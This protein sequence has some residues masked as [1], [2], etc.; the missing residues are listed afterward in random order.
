MQHAT[1]S[2]QTHALPL[3]ASIDQ[4]NQL[5]TQTDHTIQQLNLA[6]S[7]LMQ[8]L[9]SVE[10]AIAETDQQARKLDA[11]VDDALYSGDAATARRCADQSA[12]LRRE[13][14]QLNA[15][16]RNN[17]SL[18]SGLQAQLIA[19]RSGLLDDQ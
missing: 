11:F 6:W 1:S 18:A 7:S 14:E 13:L 16:F 8:Q 3:V 15:Q 17:K 5:L 4:L 9:A 10:L 12:R 19:L 2:F